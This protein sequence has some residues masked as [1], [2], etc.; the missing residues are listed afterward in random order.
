MIAPLGYSKKTQDAR[1]VTKTGMSAQIV[2][3]VALDWIRN[4]FVCSR[5]RGWM[6]D[7][8]HLVFLPR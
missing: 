4:E 2:M 1:V 8:A 7:E 5:S 3:R 6:M